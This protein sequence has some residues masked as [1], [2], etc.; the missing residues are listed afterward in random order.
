MG[1][2]VL[3]KDDEWGRGA[4]PMAR[5]TSVKEGKDK[6]VRSCTLQLGNKKGAVLDRPITKLVLI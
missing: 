3:V 2:I 4:W 5:I 1:D 6:R